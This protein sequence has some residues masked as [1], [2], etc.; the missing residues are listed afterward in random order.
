M[1][2]VGPMTTVTRPSIRARDMTA[3]WRHYDWLLVLLVV[4]TSVFGLFMIHSTT[5]HTPGGTDVLRQAV[6]GV[7]G[8][9]AGGVV[10]AVDYRRLRDVAPA[11]Y[12]AALAGLLGVLT[13]LG[14]EV[15]GTRGWYRFGGF[16][17]QPAEFTKYIVVLAVATYLGSLVEEKS[18]GE[19]L[20]SCALIAVPTAL[21]LLQ[22]D[23][24]TMLVFVVLAAGMFLVAG[25][26][27]RMLAFLGMVAVIGAILIVTTGLLSDERLSRLT[28]FADRDDAPSAES[29]NV[30]Q[31]ERA[32][33]S[34]GLTGRGYG[35]GPQTVGGFVPAQRTDFIF[36]VPGEELGFFGAGA[37]LL[38]LA[39]I[40]WRIY[41]AAV[42]ARDEV[43]RLVCIGVLCVF[44]FHIF[45]NVGMN[46][47]I[48]PVTGIPLPFVS[49]GGSS[50]MAS[51]I[52][53]GMVLSVG[54]RRHRS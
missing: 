43:G 41:R 8:L 13:P 37:L 27:A 29:Y 35:E 47:G 5:R 11:L 7:A 25:F 16:A 45:E 42:S 44:T 38:L 12:I 53:V 20:I 54:A 14:N 17:L 48:M 4:A 49:Y 10:A 51:F 32:I 36:T 6:F 23:V 52:G 30:E 50:I 9:V 21:V 15:D 19:L 28:S 18:L 24:G 1:S 3:P 2:G 34:G 40:V 22:P 46:L 39:A 33:S 26:P 31:A